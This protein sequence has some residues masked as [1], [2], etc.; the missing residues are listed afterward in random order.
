MGEMTM[1]FFR[2]RSRTLKGDIRL[3][4]DNGRLRVER[5]PELRTPSLNPKPLVTR[6]SWFAAWVSR[7]HCVWA[8]QPSS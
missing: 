3:A 1:R 4:D 5:D 2:V 6:Q 8:L 7:S